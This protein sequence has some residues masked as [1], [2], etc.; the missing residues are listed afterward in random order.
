MEIRTIKHSNSP[1]TSAVVLVQK[2][3]RSLRFCIDLRKLNAHTGKDAYS[4]PRITETLDC[5]N[6][7]QWFTSLDLKARYWQVELDEGSKPPTGFTVGPLG[8]YECESMPTGLTNAP[9][10]FQCLM[11][12]CLGKLHLQWCIIYLDF[13]IIFSK[14]P[15]EQIIRLRAVF[16]KHTEAALNLKPIKCE[17]FKRSV[18]YLGQLFQR[19]DQDI[20]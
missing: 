8:F 19:W 3:E 18:A 16:E 15:K 14:T 2:K 5:L 1:W 20:S 6:G 4:L 12:T 17:F 11:E 7:A 10:T 13:I 9:A